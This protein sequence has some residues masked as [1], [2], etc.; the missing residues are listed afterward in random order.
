MSKVINN[1]CDVCGKREDAWEVSNYTISISENPS[2]TAQS[3]EFEKYDVCKMCCDSIV[4]YIEGCTKVHK[5]I[6]KEKIGN[7]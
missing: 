3:R 4:K 6:K 5:S 7:E 2:K 1:V